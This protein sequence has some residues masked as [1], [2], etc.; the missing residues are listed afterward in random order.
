MASTDRRAGYDAA[1]RSVGLIDRSARVRIELSGPERA[2]MLHNLTTNDIKRLKPGAGTEAFLTS[3]QGRTL[4]FLAVHC[5]ED[6]LL[7]RS[8]PGTAEAI[9]AHIAKFGLFE[10]ATTRDVSAETAEWHLVGPEAAEVLK[11]VIGV[12]AG[13]DL[14]LI[15]GTYQGQPVRVIRES[16]TSHPGI[17]LIASRDGSD[18]LSAVLIEAVTARGGQRLD[19]EEFEALR[20]EAGTPAFGRDLS[21]TNL[22]QEVNRD[23]RAISFVKGC[24]LGQETV[25]RLDAL[26]HV[27]KILFGA[28]AESDRVPPVGSVLRADDKD[29]GVVTSSAFSPGWSR[30]VV[31]GYVKVAHAKPGSLL[32]AVS[33]EDVVNIEVHGWPM[34]PG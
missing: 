5:E 31:L 6:R 19:P 24:Y 32:T 9:L 17:T 18:S 25:A 29:V 7:V 2:K 27:N 14:S 8:D 21:A 33:G 13:P 26:G 10:D 3:S 16:P 1:S 15:S 28:V 12:E 34:L 11:Q 22:P 23:A 30:A 4:A 20:I